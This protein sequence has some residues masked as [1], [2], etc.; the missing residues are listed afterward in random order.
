MTTPVRVENRV[1]DASKKISILCLNY[2][3]DYLLKDLNVWTCLDFSIT[4]FIY[5]IVLWRT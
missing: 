5:D 2:H 3:L 4:L 1:G